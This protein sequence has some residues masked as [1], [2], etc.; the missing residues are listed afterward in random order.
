MPNFSKIKPSKESRQ[1]LSMPITVVS[2]SITANSVV[3]KHSHSWGQ[4]VY[5]NKGVLLVATATDRYIVPPEQGV[6]V[7][8]GVAHEVTAISKVELTSFYF[9]NNL[10]NELPDKCCVL[11]VNNFLK[12]LILEANNIANDYLW[13]GADGLLLRL[14]LNKLS[15]APSIIFQ[16]P[17]PK[18]SRLLTMLSLIEKEPSNSYKLEQWGQKIGASS[19]TLSRLF[20]KETG[21]S[22]TTWR[23]RLNIQIAISQLSQGMSITNISFYLG[24]ESPSAFTHMF[25]ENTGMTPSFYRDN[26]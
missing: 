13:S 10:L 5:A 9:D 21:L 12:T 17:Y 23:Q 22:Y 18:D 25:K 8:P 14:I 1:Q 26:K 19:R 15:L 16:L 11:R 3:D 20:K 4:F 7:L 24:Y 6:W 2:R